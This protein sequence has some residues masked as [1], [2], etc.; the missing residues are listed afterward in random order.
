MTMFSG[1]RLFP[2]VRRIA[3]AS[4]LVLLTFGPGVRVA[5]T[6]IALVATTSTEGSAGVVAV[7]PG[8][9]ADA[10]LRSASLSVSALVTP[11]TIYRYDIDSGRRGARAARYP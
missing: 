5:G 10:P 8:P 11:D 1:Q 2:F 3:L 4:W 6:Q 7:H 9:V